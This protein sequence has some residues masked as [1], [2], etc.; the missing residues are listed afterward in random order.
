MFHDDAAADDNVRGV[1]LVIGLD[2]EAG[3]D[4]AEHVTR[5]LRTELRELDF[6]AA[7]PRSSEEM[8]QGA[9]GSG[10]DWGTL[11]VTLSASGGVF[12]VLI[13]SIQGWLARTRSA[14]SITMTIDGDTITLDRASRQ[15]RDELVRTWVRRHV[16]E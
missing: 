7:I 9:K 5:Q 15:E 1:R 6:E 8:P 14:N 2:P 16:R 11:L 12:T 3:S 13:T 4:E 10:I